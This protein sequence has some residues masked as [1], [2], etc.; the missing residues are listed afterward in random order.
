MGK[1][2]FTIV[3]S[4]RDLAKIDTTQHSW[5]VSEKAALHFRFH[6]PVVFRVIMLI[7][8]INAISYHILSFLHN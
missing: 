7:T 4:E 8:E 1:T 3:H 6:P 5:Y 2:L